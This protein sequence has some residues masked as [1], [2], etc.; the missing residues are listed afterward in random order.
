MVW[1]KLLFAVLLGLVV[2]SLVNMA[3]ITVGGHIIALP[4]G[5]DMTTA[6]GISAALLQ[7]EVRH[8]IFPFLAHAVGT[9][10]GAFIAAKI[11]VQHP[12][13]SA[14]IVGS[15]FFIGGILAAKMIP[16]P[17]WF[18]VVDLIGAYFPFAWGGYLLAHPRKSLG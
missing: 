1:L 15:C 17:T 6:E 16:A 2:G 4:A 14:L 10:L 13:F 8:F 12:V 18:I 9:L 3:L 7:L 11:A 5:V